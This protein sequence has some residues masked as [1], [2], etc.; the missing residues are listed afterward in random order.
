MR[1]V[2]ETD[3]G[4]FLTLG[5]SSDQYDSVHND[6]WR[7]G[8]AIRVTLGDCPVPAPTERPENSHY[9]AGQ[10]QANIPFIP[11]DIKVDSICQ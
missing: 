2:R 11:S 3:S 7:A 1:N 10:L 9:F 6:K 4:P 8:E 5:S